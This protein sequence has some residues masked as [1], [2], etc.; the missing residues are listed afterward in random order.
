MSTRRSDTVRDPAVRTAAAVRRVL[1]AAATAACGL[2]LAGCTGGASTPTV[3]VGSKN[4]TEQLVLAE[5]MAQTI[6]AHTGLRVARKLNLGGT[7][8]CHAALVRGDL[9][10]YAEYTGTALTA[11][12]KQP[13]VADPERAY[14]A[15][16][17]AYA[18]RFNCRWLAPF[19]FNNTYTIAVRE[20]FAAARG[21]A[22]ISDLAPLAPRLTAGFTAEFAVREDGYPG[23]REVYGL[24]FGDVTDMDPGLMYRAVAR[25][26][27][28]A[29]CA[30][31]TD[32]RIAAY[33]LRTLEDDRGFFPPYHAAPVVR[34]DT[35]ARHPEL[36]AALARLDG[37]L[38]NDAMRKLNFEVDEKHRNAA[39]VAH[40]FLLERGVLP[41]RNKG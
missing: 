9:D 15:V 5:I 34:A 23:L 19:G 1:R 4:F 13:V 31:A 38:D 39:D 32:G 40:A 2:A 30:F 16:A 27:V 12:L 36:R 17:G 22:S 29:I 3:T 11:I 25:G 14:T 20:D 6:E 8:I 18:P 26:D 35:L 24:A 33:A 37:I 41:A 7:M 21:L 28:D 10:L